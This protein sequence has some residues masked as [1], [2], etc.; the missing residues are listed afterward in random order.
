M[1]LSHADKEDV[2]ECLLF[3]VKQKKKQSGGHGGFNWK[4]LEPILE[5]MEKEGTIQQKPTINGK[6]YFLKL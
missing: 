1:E 6:G 2:K 3:L 5:E 4:D